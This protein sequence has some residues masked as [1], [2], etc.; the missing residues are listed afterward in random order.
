MANSLRYVDHTYRDFSQYTDHGG[1]LIKHKKCNN[2]F[3]AKVHLILSNPDH[4]HVITWMPHGRAWKVLDKKALIASV[5]PQYLVCKKYESFTRQLN[6][7]G[8][9]RLYQSGPDLGCYYHESFLRG[10]PKLTCLI[11]R[12]PPN[13]GRATAFAAG[14]PNFYRI[15]EQYPVPA[16]ATTTGH[17]PPGSLK[18]AGGLA[19]AIVA[20]SASQN[21]SL[22]DQRLLLSLAEPSTQAQIAQS[23]ESTTGSAVAASAAHSPGHKQDQSAVQGY[24]TGSALSSAMPN[25]SSHEAVQQYASYQQPLGYYANSHAPSSTYVNPPA[26]SGNN[27]TEGHNPQHQYNSQQSHSYHC[28]NNPLPDNTS[29]PKD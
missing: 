14:E 5:L 2:N 10:L 26:Y 4:S 1:Q 3:P 23:R 9:K 15:S 11:R 6:G 28:N 27:P 17:I 29:T 18:G 7:W 16:M 20:A 24:T 13:Q 8:F 25:N 22:A 19:V 21:H 12:L